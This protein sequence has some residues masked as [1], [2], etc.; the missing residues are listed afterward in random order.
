MNDLAVINAN[1]TQKV[2][3]DFLNFRWATN[4]NLPERI[5]HRYFFH[6]R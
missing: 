1:S 6:T 4:E 3:R 2:Y 5:S